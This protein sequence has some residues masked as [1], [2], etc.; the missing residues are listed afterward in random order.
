M[1]M[2]LGAWAAQA[3]TVA[4]DLGIVDV[5]AKGPLN[6]EELAA[7]VGADVDAVSRLLVP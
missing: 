1:E 7:A 5:L 4:A 6:A 2:I 3:I